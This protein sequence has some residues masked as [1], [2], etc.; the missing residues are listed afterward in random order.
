MYE[1]NDVQESRVNAWIVLTKQNK[2]YL[3]NQA[4]TFEG[5]ILNVNPHVDF[6]HFKYNSTL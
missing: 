4:A 3:T 2:F 5:Q 1:Y 6:Y